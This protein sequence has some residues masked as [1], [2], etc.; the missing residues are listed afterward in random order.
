MKRAAESE[1]GD[2][3]AKLPP[4]PEERR[5]QIG[6]V[7]TEAVK[8]GTTRPIVLDVRARDDADAFKLAFYPATQEKGV[9]LLE[10]LAQLRK[11]GTRDYFL[12]HHKILLA[13]ISEPEDADDDDDD[14][15]TPTVD[16]ECFQEVF[17]CTVEEMG[18]FVLVGLVHNELDD[19]LHYQECWLLSDEL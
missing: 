3:L 10:R 12:A 8:L 11:A 7:I 9:A 4:L 16:R 15:G 2:F 6:R 19:F 13:L 5:A 18:R 1:A 17:R 14:D